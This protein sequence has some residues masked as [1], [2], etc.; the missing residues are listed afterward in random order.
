MYSII[1][2]WCITVYARV[3]SEIC[4]VT[5]PVKLLLCSFLQQCY[6]S[7]NTTRIG[8]DGAKRLL[9]F[10]HFYSIFE[11]KL[12]MLIFFDFMADFIL[13]AKNDLCTKDKY[14]H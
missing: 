8:L 3:I 5:F 6:T 9:Y 2:V 1:V 11:Y 12:N 7:V 13:D 4:F 10:H 14:F